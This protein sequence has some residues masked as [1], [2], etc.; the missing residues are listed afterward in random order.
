MKIAVL[1]DIH[2]NYTALEKC[3]E[4]AGEQNI[5][6]FLFLGDYLGELPYPQITMGI[7][8]SMMKKYSCHFVKGNKEDYWTGYKNSGEQGWRETDSATGSLFYT[9]HNLTPKDLEFFEKLPPS[10]E[11]CFEGLP[12][13]T[14]CHGSPEKVNEKLLPECENTFSIMDAS[15]NAYILCGHTHIQ[16]LIEH[17]GKFVLNAG[18]VG[19]PLQSHGKSQFMILKGTDGIWEPEFVSLDYDVEKV[20]GELSSSGLNEKAPSWS[21]ISAHLLRTG[22]VSHGDILQRAMELCTAATGKCIWPDIPEVCWEQAINEM[23][24]D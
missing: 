17:N 12:P 2:G 4:Y 8:Y 14:I 15:P 10:R 9:Y 16:G 24:G 18:S 6:T 1:S 11:L 23:I 20:I 5:S 21:K 7:L 22:E 19:I 13:L 3:I